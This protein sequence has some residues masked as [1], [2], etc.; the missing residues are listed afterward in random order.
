MRQKADQE[1]TDQAHLAASIEKVEAEVGGPRPPSGS[2]AVQGMS[3]SWLQPRNGHKS[4]QMHA[5]AA[6]QLPLCWIQLAIA[7][8]SPLPQ[9]RKKFEADR[10]AE[11]E[12]RKATL[13]SW[14]WNESAGGG[15]RQAAWRVHRLPAG[16]CVACT[17]GGNRSSA[18]GPA[19]LELH[20]FAGIAPILPRTF[21][22]P[23]CR[24][25]LQCAAPMVLRQKH[26]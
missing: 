19:V 15:Q 5:A 7:P 22:A 17:P 10:K 13:G 25:L 2:I 23:F 16:Q 26:T 12:H 21:A 6:C 3:P 24:V 4:A 9:A 14:E 11:E 8:H 1:K 20:G 18:A